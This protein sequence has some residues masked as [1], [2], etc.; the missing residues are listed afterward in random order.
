MSQATIEL[1][2]AGRLSALPQPP[3]P[4][5]AAPILI[6]D[7]EQSI[8][9]PSQQAETTSQTVIIITAV[10]LVTG[11]ASMLNGIITVSLPTVATDLKLSTDLLFW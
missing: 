5:D 3:S 11:T 10:T 4:S 9:G 2:E 6:V 8:Q 1:Q 7:T